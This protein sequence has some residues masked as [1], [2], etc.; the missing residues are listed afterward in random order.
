MG[1][2]KNRL[3]QD[4]VSS[5]STSVIFGSLWLITGSNIWLLI[6]LFAGVLPTIGSGGKL[7][8]EMTEGKKLAS[9][10]PKIARVRQEKEILRVAKIEHGRIT[11]A[12]AALK[13]SCSIEEA[14]QILDSI[15]EKGYAQM[16]VDDNGRIVYLFPE[17]YADDSSHADDMDR[18]RQ[19][20]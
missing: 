3:I 12:V 2:R 1:K 10:A 4:F 16:D 8:A 14:N 13:S 11:P 19:G 18:F 5:L 6:G 9:E 17:F 15:V 20:S 7:L